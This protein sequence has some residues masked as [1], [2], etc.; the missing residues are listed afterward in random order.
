MNLCFFSFSSF[1][2][3]VWTN[4]ETAEKQGGVKEVGHTT[5]PERLRI[6][7]VSRES[8]P[9]V[10]NIRS[11]SRAHHS[12]IPILETTNRVSRHL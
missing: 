12:E 9:E 11:H 4:H 8:K 1:F 2:L 5:G 10:M 6:Y 3:E 7:T